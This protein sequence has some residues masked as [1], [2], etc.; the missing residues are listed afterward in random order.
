MNGDISVDKK[1]KGIEREERYN[2]NGK[3]EERERAKMEVKRKTR[4]REDVKLNR[5]LESRSEEEREKEDN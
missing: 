4:K 5:I 2:K 3:N 1:Q